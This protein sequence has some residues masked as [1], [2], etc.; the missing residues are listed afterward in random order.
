[1]ADS[2]NRYELES[3]NPV[4]RVKVDEKRSGNQGRDGFAVLD[5]A[6]PN[7]TDEYGFASP[8]N[9]KGLAPRCFDSGPVY[10]D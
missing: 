8:R 3:L 4:P 1:M 2:R 6:R 7:S 10:E 9:R 5:Q